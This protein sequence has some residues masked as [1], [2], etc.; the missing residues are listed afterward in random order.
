[1][2]LFFVEEEEED[3]ISNR[4][5]LAPDKTTCQLSALISRLPTERQS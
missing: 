4:S 1:M 2:N 5:F 3:G